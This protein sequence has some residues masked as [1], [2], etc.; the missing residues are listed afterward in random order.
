[1]HFCQMPK[2]KINLLCLCPRLAFRFTRPL[3]WLKAGLLSGQG[4]NIQC[5]LSPSAELLRVSTNRQRVWSGLQFLSSSQVNVIKILFSRP[6]TFS[7]FTWLLYVFIFSDIKWD[8]HQNITFKILA[9]MKGINSVE[10]VANAWIYLAM[11]LVVL[12]PLN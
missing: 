2:E 3:R 6:N 9:R 5:A 7:H 12:S 4:V 8:K 1:M 11:L 10:G